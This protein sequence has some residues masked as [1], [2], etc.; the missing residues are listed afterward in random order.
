MIPHIRKK[1]N[2][3]LKIGKYKYFLVFYEVFHI[4]LNL[5]RKKVFALKKLRQ[6]KEKLKLLKNNLMK[7]L[8]NLLQILK[9]RGKDKCLK[10]CPYKILR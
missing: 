10:D 8:L 5:Y 7:L 4:L 6:R 9:I 3:L 2:I 1:S